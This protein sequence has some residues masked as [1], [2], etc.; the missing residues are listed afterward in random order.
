MIAL[1]MVSPTV[2]EPPAQAT[3]RKRLTKNGESSKLNSKVQVASS[4]NQVKVSDLKSWG[5]KV[6]NSAGCCGVLSRLK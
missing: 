5:A 2:I 4:P 1:S 6:M 3:N